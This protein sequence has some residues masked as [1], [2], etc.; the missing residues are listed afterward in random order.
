MHGDLEKSSA[1]E[2]VGYTTFTTHVRT[3]LPEMVEKWADTIEEFRRQDGGVM[4]QHPIL[5]YDGPMFYE[6][7]KNDHGLPYNPIKACVVPRPIG[8]IVGQRRWA[9]QR[10][11]LAFSAYQYSP[12]ACCFGRRPAGRR[13]GIQR[14]CPRDERVVTIWRAGPARAMNNTGLIVA[15]M[16]NWRKPV[17]KPCSTRWSR[18][19]ARRAPLTSCTR[20]SPCRATCH[21]DPQCRIRCDRHPYRGRCHHRRQRIRRRPLNRCAPGWICL[22]RRASFSRSR[23]AGR[24]F[25]Q[26]QAAANGPTPDHREFASSTSAVSSR[27]VYQLLGD[28]GADIDQDREARRRR[29]PQLGTALHQDA[30]GNGLKVPF[31]LCQPQQSA[32]AIDITKQ[33]SSI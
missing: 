22:D 28:Y 17:L 7:E 8:W 20:S 16:A 29:Y 4:T 24:R 11:T 23:Y 30:D 6:T 12:P 15:R 21:V 1:L 10:G 5:K 2:N 32:V 13:D 14:Q 9:G 18:G 27:S 26:A 33:K 3:V 31:I 19:Q 25:R